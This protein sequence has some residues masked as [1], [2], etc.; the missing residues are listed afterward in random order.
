MGTGWNPPN[1]G[2]VT[3]NIGTLANSATATVTIVIT[4]TTNGVLLNTASV[5]ATETDMRPHTNTAPQ[6]TSVSPS[7]DVGVT[8]S[9]S[10]DPVAVGWNVTYTIVVTNH[11][12]SSATAVT[13]TDPLPAGVTFVSGIGTG[14]NPPSQGGVDRHIRTLPHKAPAPVNL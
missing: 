14:C 11:G 5:T 2:I 10:P 1:M 9:D 4:P 3:C 7:A 6:S 8:K 13:L 12:P